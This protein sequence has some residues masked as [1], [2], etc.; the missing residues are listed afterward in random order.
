MHN[1]T[2]A[3]VQF[4][5]KTLGKLH[6]SEIR[7]FF[8]SFRHI[9]KKEMWSPWE[10]MDNSSNVYRCAM[11]V[12]KN[13]H[14]DLSNRWILHNSKTDTC[15][16]YYFYFA[17]WRSEW[18]SWGCYHFIVARKQPFIYVFN[19]YIIVAIILFGWSF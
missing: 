14:N 10:R 13:T 5:Y 1:L 11:W 16:C 15:N 12:S 2:R 18:Q 19:V 6:L 17:G 4:Q 3:I 8:E 7:K 9:W